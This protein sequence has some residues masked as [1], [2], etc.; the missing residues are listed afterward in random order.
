MIALNFKREIRKIW[1]ISRRHSRSSDFPEVGYFTF[2]FYRGRERFR[3]HVLKLLFCSLNLLFGDVLVAVVFKFLILPERPSSLVHKIHYYMARQIRAFWLI[4][5]WSGFRHTDC[6]R[7]NGHKLCISCFRK[8]ANSK[9]AWPE[10]HIINC[11]LTVASSSR[12]GKY[13]LSAVFVRTL[14]RSVRM[15]LAHG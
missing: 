15:A 6:F 8:P 1:K 10:C 4:L 2:L 14:L 3:T 13:W 9:Q 5:S 11:L 12:T 7:G